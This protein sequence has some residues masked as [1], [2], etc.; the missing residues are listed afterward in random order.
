MAESTGRIFGTQQRTDRSPASQT[1]TMFQFLDRSASPLFTAVRDL[2]EDWLIHVPHEHRSDLVGSF[3][4]DS[5]AFYS[6]FWEL[7]LHEMYRRSGYAVSIHP[8]VPGSSKH[9]DFLV[10][11]QGDRFYVEAVQVGTST[12]D[13]AEKR[14][15]QAAHDVLNTE[16]TDRFSLPMTHLQIGPNPLP[17]K[18]LRAQL[19]AWLAGL[20]YAAVV[21]SLAE[22][23]EPG[24]VMFDRLPR[25]PWQADGW[26]LEFHA[27]P[28]NPDAAPGNTPMI[29]TYGDGKAHMIDKHT[30]LSRALDSKANKYGPLDAPLVIAVLD[31]SG[32][33][34][35]G[36]YQIE[37]ALFGLA[38]ARP[39]ASALVPQ[40]IH[41]GGHWLTRAGW[42]RGH[43]PQ[44][45]TA[46]TFNPWNVTDYPPRLWQTLESGC[47][48]PK[49]PDFLARVDLTG[50]DPEVRAGGANPF[51][52]PVGWPGERGFQ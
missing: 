29:G 34:S 48:S 9:P 35:T 43:A 5:Q 28:L 32:P 47:Q 39:A 3:R 36:D 4:K 12:E 17:T 20:D 37:Q 41:T 25:L 42:R 50:S 1:D 11:G 40:D 13:L 16:S 51:D 2:L 10:T 21:T 44:V 49:Q 24:E 15:L 46:S 19:R 52:L 26:H 30:G 23:Q 14:R 8:D 27:F 22:P 7:Y 18:P 45:I 38:A 31:N 33:P 6:A